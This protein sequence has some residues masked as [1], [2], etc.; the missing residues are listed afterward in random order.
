MLAN[1]TIIHPISWEWTNTETF[2]PLSVIGSFVN[3]SGK[4]KVICR[5]YKMPVLDESS[6]CGGKENL[7]AHK[8][9]DSGP[10]SG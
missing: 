6:C 2:F 7:C 10:A 4:S 3:L 9:Q 5:S 1:I 8:Y